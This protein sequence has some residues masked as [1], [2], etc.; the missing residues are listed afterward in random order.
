MSHS[1]AQSAERLRNAGILKGSFTPGA[2]R[3]Q[4]SR[5]TS[6][7]RSSGWRRRGV[8]LQRIARWL[9]TSFLAEVTAGG[10]WRVAGGE[11]RRA[12]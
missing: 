1:S 9:P 2:S 3:S 5:C 4:V 7:G 11:S 8:P 10:V 12:R 6:R